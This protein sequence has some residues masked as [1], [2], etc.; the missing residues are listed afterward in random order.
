[1]RLDEFIDAS[2]AVLGDD[3]MAEYVRSSLINVIP[4]PLSPHHDP[5]CAYFEFPSAKDLARVVQRCC[6]VRSAIDVW[7]DGKSLEEVHQQALSSGK[8]NH[9]FKSKN[10][11][12]NSWRVNFRRFGR[13]G[14]SG[15]DPEEKRNLLSKFDTLLRSINGKVTL[16]GAKHKLLLLEDWSTFH[17]DVVIGKFSENKADTDLDFFFKPSR[18]LF[19]IKIA[20]GP[21]ISSK[22]AVRNRPYIGTTTMDAISSHLAANAALTSEGH[23]ILDPFCGTGSLLIS[24][25]FLGGYVIGSDIDGDCLG[26]VNRTGIQST[27]RSKNANFRR[28][29][30]GRSDVWSQLNESASSNFNF[31]SLQDKLV[32]LMACNIEDW[33]TRDELTAMEFDAIISDPP[34]GKR[35]RTSCTPNDNTNGSNDQV[36]SSNDVTNKFNEDSRFAITKILEVANQRLKLGGKL[37]FWL[38][39]EANLVASDVESLLRDYEC[40]VQCESLQFRRAKQQEINNSVWRWLCVYQKIGQE[41]K[42]TYRSQKQTITAYE[43]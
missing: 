11:S 10:I 19:G 1:M 29:H 28:K 33:L 3:K 41:E 42:T 22:F 12:E 24:A 4:D 37:V 40:S 38:P 7:G 34:F 23:L 35:E 21:S 31:Y 2:A 25:S 26:V 6:L 15:L 13:I 36:P 39:T 30:K 20:E 27:E 16:S 9:Y 8:V 14:D 5:I 43:T 18:Y 17:R 32:S